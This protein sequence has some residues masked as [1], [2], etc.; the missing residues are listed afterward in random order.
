MKSSLSLKEN[1]K[2][3]EKKFYPWLLSLLSGL[4]FWL[5]W[6]AHPFT[7]LLFVAIAPLFAIEAHITKENYHKPGITFFGFCYLTLFIWNVTTTWWVVNSTVVGALFMLVANAALMC[8]PFQLFRFTK[9]HMGSFYGYFGFILYW[10]SFEY[11]HLN[12]DLSWPWLNLGNGFARFPEWVQWYEYSGIFG[13]TLWLLVANI[14]FFFVFFQDYAIFKGWIRWRSLILTLLLIILPVIFSLI[15]YANYNNKGAEKEAVILQ[16]NIDPYKEKF[17]SGENYIPFEEQVARFIDLSDEA[18]SENTDFLVW[19]ETAIDKVFREK[20][21]REQEIIRKIINFKEKYPDL[22]M[23][24]GLTSYT[25]Y[26]GK[27]E[28]APTA[29][30]QENLGYYDIFNTAYF[31]SDHNSEAFYHKSKL[32]PGVEIMPYPQALGFISDLLFDL[33]GTSGGYGRQKHPTVFEDGEG[34]K[35]APAICYE[36]IYGAHLA[37]FVRNG[38]SLIFIITNDGWWGNT[39]GHQQHLHYATL[40]AVELRKSIARSANTGISAFIDQ[41]GEIYK[42]TQY[43][44]EKVIKG[45]IKANNH[46]T[47]YARYGDYL[48]RTAVWLAVLVL[49]GTLVKKL[50]TKKP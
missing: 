26:A 47:F 21:I 2:I 44:E 17:E 18:L 31:I 1:P 36:S 50:K 6:P 16:P 28:A 12:W 20:N 35:V 5:G 22:S 9:K 19:P 8:I 45:T 48:G 24:T 3:T 42:P 46:L 32:V 15:I 14:A 34:V 49:L 25:V 10:M 4:L 37:R 30:F 39:P 29:R 41:R 13:G 40:R 43:N 38:A 7:F 27:Q 11:M 33:G 23:V